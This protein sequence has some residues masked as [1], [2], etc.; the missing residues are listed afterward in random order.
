MSSYFI[1]P[2]VQAAVGPNNQMATVPS[3]SADILQPNKV[4]FS[5]MPFGLDNACLLTVNDATTASQLSQQPDT[6]SF[7]ANLSATLAD[8]DVSTLGTFLQNLN[9]PNSQLT[10]GQTWQDVLTIVAELMLANQSVCGVT[11]VPTFPAGTNTASP[12]SQSG[13]SALVPGVTL[14]KGAGNKA[15]AGGT[16]AAPVVAT[17]NGPYD[18]SA[19]DPNATVG[20]S[21]IQLSQQFTGP[22]ILG[23]AIGA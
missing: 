10:A 17:S 20:D 23:E 5:C 21:L 15:Q 19:L 1:M 4:S 9:I 2:M 14:T 3:H 13:A 7:P 12:I 22:I 6:F 8:G 11:G 16:N 18:F